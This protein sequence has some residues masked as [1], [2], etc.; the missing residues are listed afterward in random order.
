MSGWRDNGWTGGQYSLWRVLLSVLV[1]ALSIRQLANSGGDISTLALAATALLLSIP[2]LSGWF[3]GPAA[4]LLAPVTAGLVVLDSDLPASLWPLIAALLL[5]ALAPAAP[6]GSAMSR[7]RV[8]P[9]GG[10]RLP[11]GLYLGGW[12]VLLVATVLTAFDP[13]LDGSSWTS[14]AARGGVVVTTLLAASPRTRHL[15]WL[16]AGLTWVAVILAGTPLWWL[17]GLVPVWFLAAD[18][19]WIPAGGHL[20]PK[21]TGAEDGAK[22]GTSSAGAWLFYDGGC[23][24]CHR[25]VRLVLAEDRRED[26]MRL[27]PLGGTAFTEAIEAEVREDLP[28]SI[29]VVTPA[30]DVLCRS[31]AVFEIARLLG[32]WW[33]LLSAASRAVPRPLIDVGYR[34]VAAIRFRIFGRTSAACPLLPPELR[35]RF[36]L[37]Y[38]E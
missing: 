9:D 15:A 8:D 3:D 11:G 32:G 36:D 28:E 31:A 25:C 5:H 26:P 4:A 34:L 13:A 20:E 18:P 17:V 7:G 19:G 6:F 2:L 23:G 35:E 10:W 33:R 29:V 21:G 16:L 12:M 1:L 14:L 22:D 37:R 30:G 38:D 27:A 24:L